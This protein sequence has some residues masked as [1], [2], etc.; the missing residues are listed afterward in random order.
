MEEKVKKILITVVVVIVLAYVAYRVGILLSDKIASNRQSRQLDNAIDRK[1]LSYDDSQYEGFASTLYSAMK[2]IGTDKDS[3]S[4]V[5]S[6]M[7]TR[8]DVLKLIST[9]GVKD[10]EN[11]SEWIDGDFS[12]KDKNTYINKVLE[13]NSINYSF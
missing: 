13:A 2:G 7:Q 3:C 12:A 10:G 9:F 5:F 11:L 4:D 8:S 6:K 1:N